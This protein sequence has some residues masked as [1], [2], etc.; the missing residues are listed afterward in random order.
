MGHNPTGQQDSSKSPETG[1]LYACRKLGTKEK[2]L[3][4]RLVAT[5]QHYTAWGSV[6][7]ANS[8]LLHLILS[9]AVREAGPMP[10][11]CR[12]RLRKSFTAVEYA[13]S[14]QFSCTNE[15]NALLKHPSC[16]HSITLR[17]SRENVSCLHSIRFAVGDRLQSDIGWSF[18]LL[19]AT[20]FDCW[21]WQ[22]RSKNG[23]PRKALGETCYLP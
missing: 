7:C 9:Q 6:R 22:H 12:V 4:S 17:V 2:V 15:E 13:R 5:R 8:T 23:L 14:E 18:V 16:S 11:L 20:I 3:P 10:E 19:L 1:V 21:H